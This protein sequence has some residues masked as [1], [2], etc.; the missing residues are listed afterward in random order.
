MKSMFEVSKSASKVLDYLCTQ[1][2][3]TAVKI[4]NSNVYMAVHV[5]CVQKYENRCLFSVA[6][7]YEQFGD[8]M[9][10]PEITYLK[11]IT[12][13]GSSF[14][15]VTYRQDS[16]GIYQELT[17]LSAKLKVVGFRNSARGVARFTTTWM[18]NIKAQQK[19]II[20]MAN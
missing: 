12:P 2:E 20:K 14:F 3:V 18:S 8:L 1:A 11:V 6:H 19:L 7:Y 13:D 17:V 4:S 5:E 15:P 16:L 9:A 10:D